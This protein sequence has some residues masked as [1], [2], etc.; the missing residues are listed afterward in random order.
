M[1]IPALFFGAASSASV[2]AV[3]KGTTDNGVPFVA[4]RTSDP[5]APGGP[6]GE[7]IFPAVYLVLTH[8]QP[9]ALDTDPADVVNVTITPIVDGVAKT[10]EVVPVRMKPI[11]D[12]NN[13]PPRVHR[14]YEIG[15]S[16]AVIRDGVEAFRFALRGTFFQ[17]REEVPG[18]DITSEGAV[19][20]HEVV[21]EQKVAL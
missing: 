17:L 5:A 11:I 1:S 18:S 13:P 19:V 16:E 3:G 7:A 9:P 20:E 2:L 12:P 4:K 6:D 15:L 21:S 8:R 10:P 14:T